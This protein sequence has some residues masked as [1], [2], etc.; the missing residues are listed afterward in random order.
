[1][2]FKMSE[3]EK[4]EVVEN[5]KPENKET[6]ETTTPEETKI[7][8]DESKL[9]DSA[10]IDEFI[11]TTDDPEALEALMKMGDK[12]ETKAPE[13]TSDDDKKK[14]EDKPKGE[15]DAD[16]T[17]KDKTESPEDKPSEV[18]TIDEEYIQ[19]QPEEER[20]LYESIK[21]GTIDPKTLKNYVNAQ[22]KL[23]GDFTDE[24]PAFESVS[25]PDE[26]LVRQTHE[27]VKFDA[28]KIDDY[29]KNYVDN[30]MRGRYKDMPSNEEDVESWL[31]DLNM[32]KPTTTRNYY[33]E[34]DRFEEQVRKDVGETVE[35]FE[36][37]EKY[38]ANTLLQG[39]NLVKKFIFDNRAPSEFG[40]DLDV[41]KEGNKLIDHVIRD[42]KGGY[43]PNIVIQPF[44]GIHAFHPVNFAV[45]TMRAVLPLMLHAERM[46]GRKEGLEGGDTKKPNRT[47]SDQ[48]RG[49]TDKNITDDVISKLDSDEFETP[50]VYDKILAESEVDFSQ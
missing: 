11:E 1:M 46:R 18:I 30:E 25:V 39:I 32:N 33:R 15:G 29:I 24:L 40:I 28:N 6:T 16:K 38:R 2:E 13:A 14:P 36:N 34:R 10:S 27:P 3:E 17:A 45:K 8:I 19:K 22:K 42:G 9:K 7:E 43:D 49:K 21:G 5:E 23:Q 41:S 44:E 50:D 37:P 4:K 31:A 48:S 35:I 26:L 12:D 20:K 47:L